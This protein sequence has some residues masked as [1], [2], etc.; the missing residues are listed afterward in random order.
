MNRQFSD[1]SEPMQKFTI[2][3]SETQLNAVKAAAKK[4]RR[5]ISSYII[6]ALDVALENEPD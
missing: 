2:Y 6:A 4:S 5:S 1:E 3:I